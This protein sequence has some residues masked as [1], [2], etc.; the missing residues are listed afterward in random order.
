MG[1]PDLGY[2]FLGYRQ[3]QRQPAQ[4]HGLHS[5]CDRHR[6]LA[7]QTKYISYGPARLS[8]MALV[9][10]ETKP[11]LPTAPENLA[12][13]LQTDAAW[14]ATHHVA[15]TEAFEEWLASGGRGLSGSAR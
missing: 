1:R 12:H 6:P 9:A 10:E 2:R 4:G 14:W 7:E 8:S 15:L 13:A 11:H 5:L 3:G